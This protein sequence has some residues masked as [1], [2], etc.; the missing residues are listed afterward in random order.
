MKLIKNN[1]WLS[2]TASRK[3]LSSIIAESIDTTNPELIVTFPNAVLPYNVLLRH[4]NVCY[5]SALKVD[6]FNILL[7]EGC[8]TVQW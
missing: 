5:Y 4:E 3:V 6:T 1:T 7:N 8:G 2:V